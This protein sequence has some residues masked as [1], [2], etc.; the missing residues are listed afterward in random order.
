MTLLLL[1]WVRKWKR[2]LLPPKV[3]RVSSPPFTLTPLCPRCG[4]LSPC[5]WHME[6]P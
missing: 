1:L 2:R 6:R 3:V 5:S 4:G